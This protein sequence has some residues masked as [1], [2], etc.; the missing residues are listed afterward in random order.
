MLFLG[1]WLPAYVVCVNYT[2]SDPLRNPELGFWDGGQTRNFIK[3]H[4][5]LDYLS[6]MCQSAFG[7]SEPLKS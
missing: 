2:T 6:N 7:Y 3:R 5:T 4:C 1:R